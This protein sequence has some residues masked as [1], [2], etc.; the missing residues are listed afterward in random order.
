MARKA[1]KKARKK[2]CSRQTRR[3]PAAWLNPSH[4]ES[5]VISASLSF[6]LWYLVNS[7]AGVSTTPLQISPYSVD[8][9]DGTRGPVYGCLCS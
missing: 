6:S 3:S 9:T 7:R 5:A 2:A 1:Q 4:H 8:A